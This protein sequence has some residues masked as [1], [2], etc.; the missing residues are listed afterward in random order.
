MK[1]AVIDTELLRSYIENNEVEVIMFNGKAIKNLAIDGEVLWTS[2]PAEPFMYALN[3]DGTYTIT[4]T[5]G[6][7]SG[8]IVIPETY[9]DVAVTAIGDHALQSNNDATSVTIPA[10]VET[11]GV[12]A[13]LLNSTAT[14]HFEYPYWLYG[15]SQATGRSLTSI[16]CGDYQMDSALSNNAMV[17]FYAPEISFYD[18]NENDFMTGIEICNNNK[19]GINAYV[20]FTDTTGYTVTVLK[21][22]PGNGKAYEWFDAYAYTS[23]TVTAYFVVLPEA[24]T[25][26][27][28]AGAEDSD[29]TS[30]E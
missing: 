19:A 1:K 18:F 14:I 11:I 7:L 20:T 6:Q 9:N 3:A 13:L 28:F 15:A 8:D 4:G 12:G 24:I 25:T 27:E 10:C 30:R 17:K 5:S 22:V 29:T 16:S 21:T 26:I 23:A 2:V